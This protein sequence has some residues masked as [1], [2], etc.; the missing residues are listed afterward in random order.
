MSGHISIVQTTGKPD[1]V[2]KIRK[3]LA[4]AS[5]SDRRY[6][7]P[8]TWEEADELIALIDAK[9]PLDVRKKID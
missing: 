7:R 9:Y 2:D 3:R 6:E 5:L 8:M 4:Q 1:L